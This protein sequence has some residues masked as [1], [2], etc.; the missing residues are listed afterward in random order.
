MASAGSAEEAFRALD[1]FAPHVI[2]S[3]ITMPG[4][5][6]IALIRAARERDRQAGPA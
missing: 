6:G 3:D 5:N 4:E 2:V 1:D